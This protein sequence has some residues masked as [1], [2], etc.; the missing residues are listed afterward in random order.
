LP[1]KYR[2]PFNQYLRA[3]AGGP[4]IPG[5]TRAIRE[6]PGDVVA[7]S[8]FPL[9]HMFASLRG[10]RAS[11]RPCV[12]HGGLHP[13]DEW[14]FERSMIHRAIH[15]VHYIANTQY[16]ADFVIRRGARHERVFVIGVGVDPEMLSGISSEEARQRLG[17]D[18]GPVV[19]FI[20]QIGGHKG[21]DTLLQAMAGVWES[22]PDTQLLIAGGR[23]A[24]Y[25][26]VERFVGALPPRRRERIVLRP[27][28][29]PDE[30]RALFA[31][32]DV[33]AYPSGYESFGIAF[34]EAWAAGKPV[35]GCRRGAIPTVIRENVDGLLVPYADAPA[36]ARAI[37]RLLGDEAMRATFGE[38][39]R[40]KVLERYTWPQVAR[41]FRDVY[42][43]AI[44][45][46]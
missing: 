18:G 40:Q 37:S 39:G 1:W 38:A 9:L 4:V 17:F 43:L 6:A 34:L 42:E 14:G 33:F 13:E 12:L 3:L 28:F 2:L 25:P 36:L 29:A 21:V 10:A 45:G 24:F 30:K 44:N 5:L 16:E 41:R 32:V 27:D 8:S 7:A 35:V 15:R 22:Q 23:T 26:E 46:G 31:A 19:G 11:G 20:G